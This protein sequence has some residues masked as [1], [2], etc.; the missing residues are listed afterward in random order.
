MGIFGLSGVVVNDSLVMLDFIDQK[1]SGGASARAAII[2][3]AKGR[4]RPIL[5]T[6]VTT[7]LGF[8]PLILERSI[9]AQFMFPFAASLGFGIMITTAVLML[10][11]PALYTI[12]MRLLP[13][14]G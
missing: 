1:L 6:S 3:G 2:E 7:F 12:H 4:F 11:V 9:Q 10:V 8:T 13:P 5:L 14:P